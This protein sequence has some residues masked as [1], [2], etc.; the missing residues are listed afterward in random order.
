MR[1]SVAWPCF[2]ACVAAGLR[3]DGGVSGWDK[4][5]WRVQV[6]GVMGGR[7]TGALRF[8]DGT[9]VFTG[10]INL[11]G[12]GFSS[13]RRSMTTLD[14]SAFAGVLVEME[15]QPFA[16]SQAPLGLH[17][18]LH[19]SSSSWGFAAALAVPVSQTAAETASVF[20]PL[21]AFDR[22]SRSGWSC[23]SC[24]WDVTAVNGA[25]V[26]VLFQEGSFQVRLRSI[27]AVHQSPV[28]ATPT[29]QIDSGDVV[30]AHVIATIQSG[31]SLYDQ[32]YRELCIAIYASTLKTLVASQGAS[33]TVKGVACAGLIA[34]GVAGLSTSKSERAWL[35]RH[36]LDALLADLGAGNSRQAWLPTP[37]VAAEGLEACQT[38]LQAQTN[39]YGRGSPPGS[40]RTSSATALLSFLG[41]FTGMGMVAAMLQGIEC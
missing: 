32:G 3:L 33:E 41:S 9:L 37:Q 10:T 29:V 30:R 11:V 28:V 39:S 2:V 4:Q 21:A 14:L 1:L 35:L 18:Q 36:T 24:S 40:D 22:G 38:K 27:T 5:A 23:T 7:S 6:D 34:E 8:Q 16:P 13:I 31:A 12:G 15:T 17:L 25:D 26:Y 19:D 20:L